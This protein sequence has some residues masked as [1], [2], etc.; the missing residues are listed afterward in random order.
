MANVAAPGRIEVI[1]SSAIARASATFIPPEIIAHQDI[2]SGA[3]LVYSKLLHYA[4][5]GPAPTHKRLAAEL[6]VSPRSIRNY[7]GELKAAGLLQVRTH[8]GKP[9]SYRLSAAI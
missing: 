4:R 6:G 7:L 5:A 2:A 8:A 1:G 9:N 3:K